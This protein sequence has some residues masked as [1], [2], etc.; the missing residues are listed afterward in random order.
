MTE[1]NLDYIQLIPTSIIKQY[2][3]PFSRYCWTDIPEKITLEEITDCLIKGEE[4]LVPTETS[5]WTAPHIDFKQGHIKKIAYFVKHWFN[6]PINIDVGIPGLCYI[7][8]KVIDGNHRL[9]A[10]I[11]KEEVLK[12]AC[13][14]P[15]SVG[16][17]IEYAKELGL[18]LND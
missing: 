1:S 14:L 13:I 17:S 7:E 9:A 12:Q 16:G 11:Y 6:E 10:A 4:E 5:I 3:N 18:W 8:W 15:C 2:S